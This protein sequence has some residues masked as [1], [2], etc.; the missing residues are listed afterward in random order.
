MVFKA[1]EL[2]AAY[3]SSYHLL[4]LTDSWKSPLGKRGRLENKPSSTQDTPITEGVLLGE[5][6]PSLEAHKGIHRQ[7]RLS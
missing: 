1:G 4:L 2:R 5:E 6:A 7:R 3:H